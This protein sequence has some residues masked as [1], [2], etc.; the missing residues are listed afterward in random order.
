[1][2][3]LNII[4]QLRCD[5]RYATLVAPCWRLLF[6]TAQLARVCPVAP[7][8][9]KTHPSRVT[10]VSVITL[11]AVV[12][13]Q[14]INSDGECDSLKQWPKGWERGWGIG[15]GG[16]EPSS[17]Q[18]RGLGE[19]SAL[20]S[21][22]GVCGRTPP[23]PMSLVL[24]HFGVSK[25]A[26]VCLQHTTVFFGHQGSQAG[27]DGAEPPVAAAQWPL[28]LSAWR[29]RTDDWTRVGRR[30]VSRYCSLGVDD[31]FHSGGAMTAVHSRNFDLP[32]LT[33]PIHK[34]TVT[35]FPSI[36]MPAGFRRGGD[37]AIL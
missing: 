11:C 23:P 30:L 17:H 2:T 15:D 28:Q 13:V 4:Q 19:H 20:N 31:W 5:N 27:A 37:A 25:I 36:S 26:N 21:P 3:Q 16:S 35:L 14:C 18:L 6:G 7:H 22:S 33:L 10:S 24:M 32:T 29:D 1:M 9:I 34:V 12:K 8:C